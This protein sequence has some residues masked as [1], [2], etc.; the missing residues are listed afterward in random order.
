[1]EVTK[2]ELEKAVDELNDKICDPSIKKK[3]EK[4]MRK[5]VLKAAKLIEKGDDI[6]KET[7]TTIKSLKGNKKVKKE[8]I[9]KHMVIA[10][11]DALHASL[12]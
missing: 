12:V 1:M 5:M 6:S 2:K 9:S 10:C 7:I 11:R 8:K 3:D 4:K